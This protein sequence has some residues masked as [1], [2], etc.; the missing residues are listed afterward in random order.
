MLVKYAPQLVNKLNLKFPLL[1]DP[2]HSYL[3][4]LGVVHTLPADLIGVYQGF[5]IDLV[6]FNGDDSGQLPLPGAITVDREGIVQ[7]VSLST[8]HTQR[9]EPAETLQ[10]LKT[11]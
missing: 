1:S 5:G 4:Q 2:G 9:P 8:D 6:R 10:L 11:L 3:Q 7:N